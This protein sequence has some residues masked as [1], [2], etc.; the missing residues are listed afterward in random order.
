VDKNFYTQNFLKIYK[1]VRDY[2]GYFLEHSFKDALI[3][4]NLGA[5]RFLFLTPP[6]L[7]GVSGS[8]GEV[9]GRED[10]I[11][12]QISNRIKSVMLGLNEWIDDRR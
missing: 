9:Y 3:A 6:S 10:L 8:S 1:N 2:E 4:N 12:R 7:G 5:S 11:K